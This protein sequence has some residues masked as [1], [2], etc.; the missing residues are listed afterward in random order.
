[1]RSNNITYPFS[2]QTAPQD[3]LRTF[4]SLSLK[5]GVASAMKVIDRM[6][7]LSRVGP[8]ECTAL[9]K[10]CIWKPP[11][12]KALME[13]VT[14]YE[15]YETKDKKPKGYETSLFERKKMTMPNYTSSWAWAG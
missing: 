11:G 6:A 12:L 1:M 14:K 9:N 3:L 8:K 4:Q 5:D 2:R 7:S 15:L 10:L 13:V